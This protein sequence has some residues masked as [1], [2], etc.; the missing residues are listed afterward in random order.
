MINIH[1]KK[2]TNDIVL[3]LSKIFDGCNSEPLA[4]FPIINK[5]KEKIIIK[6]SFFYSF[7]IDHNETG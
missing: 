6:I 3:H 4:I 1:P 5:H 2:T 7:K